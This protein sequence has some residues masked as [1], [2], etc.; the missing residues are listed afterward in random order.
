MNNPDCVL[1]GCKYDKSDAIDEAE[2]DA[3]LAVI[4]AEKEIE[5]VNTINA[6]RSAKPPPYPP[7]NYMF[8]TMSKQVR[9]L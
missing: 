5:L 6:I 4:K 3:N 7:P 8:G 9:G 2:L 1:C